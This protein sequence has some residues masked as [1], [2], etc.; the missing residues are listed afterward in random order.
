VNILHLLSQNHLTG[1]EVYAVTLARAQLL[2][3]H[4]VYQISNGFFYQSPCVQK[5]LPVETASKIEFFKSVS[6]LR[7]FL[8]E[9]NI[10]LIHTHSRAAAKLA[11]WA[12]LGLST[13]TVSTIHGQQHY[14][15]SKK[16]MNQYGQMMI[17]VCENLKTHLI[18]DFKY[19][20]RQIK[21]I[22]NPID[23]EIFQFQP[24]VFQDL[25][26]RVFKIGIIGRTT[27]PK[28]NRTEQV[29]QSL[30]DIQKSHS[31][32]FEITLVGGHK[33][34][35][36]LSE[37]LLNSVLEVKVS[38]LT[39]K[40]YQQYDLVVGS[41]RV[42]VESLIAGIPVMAFGEAQFIGLIRLAQFK[43]AVQSN[44]GD[45][46][47][48]HLNGP[49]MNQKAFTDNIQSLLQNELQASELKELSELALNEFSKEL[50]EN[51]VFRVYESATFLKKYPQTIPVLMYH[52]IPKQEIDS[53][54]KIFVKVDD[55]EKHLQ[56][57][58][59]QGFQTLTFSDLEKF[60]KN[61]KPFS[62]FPKKPLI[63]TFDDGY[64][65]NLENASP[66]LKK[67]QMRAQIFLLADSQIDSNNWDKSESEPQHEI[68]AGSERQ[69]WLNSAFEIGS[70]GFSHQKI[71][72]MSAENAYTELVE[73]KKSL[74]AEFKIPINVFA[75]TYGDTNLKMSELAQKAGYQYAVNTDSGGFLIEESP[76]EIFRVNI[77]PNETYLSLYKKT[78]RWYRKYYFKK[79][80]K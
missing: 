28:K 56:F 5:T 37:S 51:S 62:E 59:N 40:D 35:L 10:E 45:I 55:F 67:Y 9:Q 72:L 14:S 38:S 42:C 73:S 13:A 26:N 64:K 19:P 76:F 41:G 50:I 48:H 16:I 18:E 23:P 30:S 4:K 8:K 27:G 47:L 53:Q 74:E 31:I 46:D 80:K 58:S 60:R 52:K 25:K 17:A 32:Q 7:S 24:R 68:V 43:M 3:K 78:S 65:D 63:L 54:H 44:F 49:Q 11:Y 22:R 79:R 77:F 33:T 12:T 61:E 75:F 66:L 69:Q 70:H 29:L 39:S 34:D 15:F 57:F 71:T 2:K 6:A 21:V 1:A 36:A 20:P